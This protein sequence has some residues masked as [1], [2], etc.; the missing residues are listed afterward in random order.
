MEVLVFDKELILMN[1]EG[2]DL[3]GKN[4]TEGIRY[5]WKI[6]GS[7]YYVESAAFVNKT[8]G[9]ES[10]ICGYTTSVSS[11]C[12]LRAEGMPCS[13]C[14]TGNTI[15]FS[16][17][18]TAKEIALQ[19]VFMVLTD[20]EC[21]EHPELSTKKREFAYMGQGEPGLSYS[22]VRYAIEITND[23]MRKINQ[24]VYRHVFA[25]CGI[26]EA[27]RQYRNDISNKYFS[28]RVTLHL[29]LH[30]LTAREKIMPVN[31]VYPVEEVLHEVEKV[32][33]ISGEKPCVGILLFNHFTKKNVIQ[34]YSNDIEEV[35][36]IMRILN[37]QLVRLSFC[38][39]NPVFEEDRF[40]SDSDVE[41]ESILRL[42]HKYGFEAKLFSSFGRE[43]R[44]ACG[45]LGGKKPDVLASSKWKLLE[46]KAIQ[47]VE[48]SMEGR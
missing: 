44:S 40:A 20:L 25:T 27:I 15:P 43:K 38:E 2:Y 26:P 32:Y 30:S 19:N 5:A 9:V 6:D 17:L 7:N 3:L 16:R 8:K 10:D 12:L 28:E 34:D 24:K 37:P 1:I 33:A 13:F 11:G 42:A 31:K 48:E 47:L 39:Y 18:L 41:A 21:D 14:A 45:M 35:K 23:V 46:N 22:Q 36:K 29:S 4:G